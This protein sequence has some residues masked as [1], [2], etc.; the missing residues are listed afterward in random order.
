MSI[1]AI[2]RRASQER[3]GRERPPTKRLKMANTTADKGHVASARSCAQRPHLAKAEVSLEGESSVTPPPGK[4][5]RACALSHSIRVTA[6]LRRVLKITGVPLSARVPSPDH[7]TEGRSN[8]RTLLWQRRP[9]WHDSIHLRPPEGNRLE[10]FICVV[11]PAVGLALVALASRKTAE[12]RTS[13][14][15]D[16]RWR[17][18]D[19]DQ[20]LGNATPFADRLE[21]N[22]GRMTMF[23]SSRRMSVTRSSSRSETDSAGWA[24]RAHVHGS[25]LEAVKAPGSVAVARS[26]RRPVVHMRRTAVAIPLIVT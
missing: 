7:S 23:T 3:R 12:V 19:S 4:V 9:C 14:K 22:P 26:G 20:A 24:G 2:A 13:G 15:D 1:G 18:Q 16:P 21:G 11:V 5:S 8:C 6:A 10:L 17:P 25:L